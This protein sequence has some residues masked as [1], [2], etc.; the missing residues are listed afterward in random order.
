MLLKVGIDSFFGQRAS[1]QV[2]L[3]LPLDLT[4]NEGH[5]ILQLKS[6]EG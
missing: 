3:R 5:K 2:P 1:A 4:I 6:F